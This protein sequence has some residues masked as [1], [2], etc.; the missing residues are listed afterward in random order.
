MAVEPGKK[1]GRYEIRS[2]LGKGGMGEVY[3]AT[4]T[5]LD[6]QVGLKV[7]LKE[8]ATDEERVRRF[9][10]EA[11]AASALNHPNIL[12]VYEI[13]EFEGT[14]YIATEL[15]KGETLRGRLRSGPMTLSDVLNISMQVATA[16]SAA[17]D[18]GIVHRDIKPENIMLRD[19]GIVKVLDF[20]LAKLIAPPRDSVDS[21][22]ETRALVDTMPGTVMGT[23]L[24]MS[25]EQARSKQA[26]ARSDVWSLAVVMYEMLSGTTPFAGET[27]NDSIAAILTQNP[28]PLDESVSPEL[29]RIV[30][31]ALQKQVDERY[32]T[33]R[34]LFLD[35]KNLKREL[36]FLE[37]LE[38]SYIP[39]KTG[40]SNV[41]TGQ[42]SENPTAVQPRTISTHASAASQQISS[43]ELVTSA[44]RQHKF[45]ATVIFVAVAIILTGFAYGLYRFL[46][47]RQSER[48]AV[49]I[50]TQRL[51]GDGKTPDAEISPDGKFL[52]YIRLEGES[53]SL[54]IK[55]IQTNSSIPIVKSDA[56]RNFSG[57]TFSKD[58]GF[59]YFNGFT[60]GGGPLTV[61]RVPTLGGTP[62]KV[63]TNAHLMQFSPDGNQVSFLRYDP[64]GH[65]TSVFVANPDGSN[66]RKIVSRKGREFLTGSPSWSPDGKYIAVGCGDNSLAPAAST[67]IKVISVADQTESELGSFRW[68]GGLDLVWHPSGD[69][70]IVVAAAGSL[71]PSQ[72]WEISY[73][74]GSVRR[75]T[76]NQNGYYSISVTSDG[77]SIVTGE[78]YSRSA[79]W[80]SSDLN[81]E[82]A[83]QVMPATSDT[84][85]ISWTADNRI[86]FASD[87][88]GDNEIWIME[89][90][91]SNGRPLTNDRVYKVTPVA[92]PDGRYVVYISSNNGRQMER[93]NIDGGNL[94][95]FDKSVYPD[96][97]D[98]SLD[99]KWIIYDSLA[100]GASRIFRVPISGGEPE[101]LT[102]YP[103]VEPRYS[104]DGTRFACFLMDEKT[105]GWTKLGVVA[106]NGGQPLK[107][108][109]LPPNTET[110]RGPVWT[111]DNK[112]ITVIVSQGERLNLWLQPVDGGVPK[113][114]TNFGS[115]VVYR[116]EYS[117]D[118]KRIAIVRGE[119]IGNAVMIT[120]YR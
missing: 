48:P 113:Q 107:V 66:E 22:G 13:G 74:S 29:R 9:T 28:P 7:L 43:S 96:N 79:V 61:Y 63:L 35:V 50:K 68:S 10:Q 95:A 49:N 37:K 34:D 20:G 119:G 111:P 47:K 55:Q 104:H 32:Q 21:E 105:E 84:W 8:V 56:I 19:D 77:K 76:G 117:R 54:W 30:K 100:N 60:Q 71:I 70:L 85:G 83:K 64:S 102:N 73:P 86:V 87:Q 36:E 89:A 24:Y 51:T 5:Q 82:N 15:V 11:R 92:S 41:S 114:I 52:A 45:G 103:A 39:N 94:M 101:Q 16:L 67:S 17:H 12:T 57:I 80:V 33:I 31:K 40:S 120:D 112:G 53:Q 2:K 23:V 38:R 62:T 116:R 115:P 98:I 65:E 6:R 1:L 88:T 90:N 93:I 25:P 46:E 3:L 26:D 42:L 97:P 75:L 109:D 118:G 27:A 81:P 59:V 44:I 108:L 72:L 69:S 110:F 18:A 99:G 14:R 58:G 106:A 91:G 4:D 78:S